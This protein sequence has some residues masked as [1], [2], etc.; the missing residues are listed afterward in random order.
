MKSIPKLHSKLKTSNAP[1]PI[2]L[3]TQSKIPILNNKSSTFT[4]SRSTNST[5]SKENT[6]L[7]LTEIEFSLTTPSKQWTLLY[8]V[9]RFLTNL[10]HI[11]TQ[12]LSS[13][14]LEICLSQLNNK[15]GS[16]LH[17]KNETKDS[18]RWLPINYITDQMKL[19]HYINNGLDQYESEIIDIINK[20]KF[21]NDFNYEKKTP[22]YAACLNGFINITKILLN[23]G[24]N[25]LQLY[26]NNEESVLDVATRMNY[27]L[28]VKFLLESKTWPIDYVKRAED[29]CV[30]NRN[31]V[32]LA[33]IRSYIKR[34]QIK[35]E[36]CVCLCN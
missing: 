34:N 11:K 9:A 36:H 24:A 32:I 15:N 35:N 25:W 33:I 20:H 6:S 18:S 13:E 2:L 12:R 8:N 7:S 5:S 17:K 31:K 23:N 22:L 14:G 19:F 30:K 27:V 29:Y 28:L 3:P 10:K 4:A 21:I 26:N 16:N 1:P